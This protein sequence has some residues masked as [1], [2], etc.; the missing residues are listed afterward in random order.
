MPSAFLV[1]GTVE[2]DTRNGW[3][4][5]LGMVWVVILQVQHDG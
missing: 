3:N 2:R 5:G 1:D 4:T